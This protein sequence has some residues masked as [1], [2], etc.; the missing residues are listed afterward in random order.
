MGTSSAVDAF[1]DPERSLGR[2][3]SRNCG[4]TSR[5]LS[6]PPESFKDA[7]MTRSIWSV[8]ALTLAVV[9]I[10][11]GTLS[12]QPVPPSIPQR[13]TFSPYLNMLRGG[14]LGLNYFGL[15]KPQQ[16]FQQAV[17]QLDARLQGGGL[18]GQQVD[19]Q[20]LGGNSVINPLLPLT[21]N[22]PS[23]D[24]LS[25]Y[26]DRVGNGASGG[27]GGQG[28]GSAA[29]YGTIGAYRGGSG[30]SV[31]RNGGMGGGAGFGGAG[32]GGSQPAFARPMGRP[33]VVPA[34]R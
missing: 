31:G 33:N 10:Q 28:F 7:Q 29:R 19:G 14:N 26:F 15:V 2:L 21:G 17:G 5:W 20:G 27:G 1:I 3:T 25:G 4:V 23:F 18:I 12:A 6:H 32:F 16:Q 13:P 22:V 34:V 24:N 30:G 11:T 8:A 9:A